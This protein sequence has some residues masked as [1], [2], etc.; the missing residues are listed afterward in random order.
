MTP[1]GPGTL[2]QGE[3]IA[4]RY[5]LN[6]CIGDGGHAAVW[7]ALDEREQRLVALKFLRPESC[8]ADEAWAV[9]QQESQ[10]TRRVDHPG[11]LWVDEPQRDGELVFLPMEYATG[12]DIKSLRGTS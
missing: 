6:Q 11:V 7:S 4:G 3:R 12:G 5:L 10:L 8:D 1:T 2:Q 9:L